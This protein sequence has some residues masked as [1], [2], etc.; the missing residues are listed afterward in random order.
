MQI[1]IPFSFFA[2]VFVYKRESFKLVPGKTLNYGPPLI[3]G[4]GEMDLQRATV[5]EWI[6]EEMEMMK[7]NREYHAGY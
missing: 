5:R 3:D 7:G 1:V 6:R 2:E 4:G